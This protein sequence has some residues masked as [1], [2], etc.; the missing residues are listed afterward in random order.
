MKDKEQEKEKTYSFNEDTFSEI[1]ICMGA[2]QQIL[3]KTSGSR[4]NMFQK[5][6]F[7]KNHNKVNELMKEFELLCEAAEK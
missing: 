6:V 7:T 2:Y 5:K 1:V 3:E 4:M